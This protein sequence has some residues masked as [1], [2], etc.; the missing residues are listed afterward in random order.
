M[1]CTSCHGIP[2]ATGEH[3]AHPGGDQC[4]LCHP[5]VNSAGTALTVRTLHANGIVNLLHGDGTWA[6]DTCH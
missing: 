1:T 6:C 4:N 2:P 3:G 5:N